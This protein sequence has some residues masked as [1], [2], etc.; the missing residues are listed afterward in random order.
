VTRHVGVL[1]SLRTR[2]FACALLLVVACGG[3][4]SPPPTV[5][6]RLRGSPPDASVTID[7]EFVGPLNVVM[8]R[9]VAL[10]KGTH[11]VTVEAQGYLPFDK[12]IEAKDQ[13]VQLDVQLVPIPD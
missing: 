12:A 7:D 6:L 2:F 11:R 10:P 1:S 8:V 3:A 4:H 5:S 13:P 9:G